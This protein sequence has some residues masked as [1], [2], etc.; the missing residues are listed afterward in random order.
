M[1]NN[2][3][4][5]YNQYVG[6]QEY[7][8]SQWYKPKF[9]TYSQSSTA[10]YLQ[11]WYNA[12]NCPHFASFNIG[13]PQCAVQGITYVNS[14]GVFNL[15]NTVTYTLAYPNCSPNPVNVPL[16]NYAMWLTFIV[17]FCGAIFIAKQKKIH[18]I[19]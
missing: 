3:A 8:V 16:D 6:N 18:Y 19:R 15:G 4:F 7:A 1:I 12:N 2:Q 14:A 9:E 11:S 5:I 13:S 10:P 17:G